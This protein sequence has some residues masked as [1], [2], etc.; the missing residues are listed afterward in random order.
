MRQALPLLLYCLFKHTHSYLPK[1]ARIYTS[2]E[3]AIWYRARAAPFF[4]FEAA[5]FFFEAVI[6]YRARA[7]LGNVDALFNLGVCYEEGR[8]VPQNF[9]AA[10]AWYERALFVFKKR[11]RTKCVMRRAGGAQ[12]FKTAVAWYERH[13]TTIYIYIYSIYTECIY[14]RIS[15]RQWVGTSALGRLRPH[16]PVA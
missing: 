5:L 4:F 8:G 10:V 16:T 15:R 9:K 14:S 3:T 12:N 6:W 11:K 7:A 13:H 1:Q 2:S